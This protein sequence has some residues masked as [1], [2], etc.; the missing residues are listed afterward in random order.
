MWATSIRSAAR[1]HGMTQERGAQHRD[2]PGAAA[3][4]Q[5]YATDPR[6]DHR[7]RG[8]FTTSVLHYE[9]VPAHAAR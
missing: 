8:A 5:R 2:R 9:V 1:V 6:F 4:M 3:Q 7:G